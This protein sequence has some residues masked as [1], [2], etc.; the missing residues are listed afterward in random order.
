M[1]VRPSNCAHSMGKSDSY[2]PKDTAAGSLWPRSEHK[3]LRAMIQF[4]LSEVIQVQNTIRPF[5]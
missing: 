2:S 3:A 5:I 1:K 4:H